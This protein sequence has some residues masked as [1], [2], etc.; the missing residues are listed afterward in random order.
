MTS[1]FYSLQEEQELIVKNIKQLLTDRNIKINTN[2]LNLV[3]NHQL[4]IDNGFLIA[5]LNDSKAN[6]VDSI[7]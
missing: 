4:V 5:Y 3:K 6:I 7:K 2:L 1:I